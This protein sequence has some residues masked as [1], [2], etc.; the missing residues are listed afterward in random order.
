M[1]SQCFVDPSVHPDSLDFVILQKHY[2]TSSL[3]ATRGLC[4]L[5]V[6]VVFEHLLK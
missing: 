5:N 1:N 2:N 3:I 6:N 4:H